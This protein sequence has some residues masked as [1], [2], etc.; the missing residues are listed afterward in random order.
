M[1][2]RIVWSL[3]IVLVASVASLAQLDRSARYS[4]ALAELVPAP[5]QAFAARHLAAEAILERDGETAL[6]LARA[7]VKVRPVPAEHMT[8]LAQARGLAEDQPGALAALS[9]AIQRGW[10]D[11]VAQ[12][13]AAE[14]ALL[15]GD[16]TT[17]TQRISALLATE[18]LP[19]EMVRQLAR[20]LQNEA[21][22][23]AFAAALA[24]PGRWQSNL[25]TRAADSVAPADLAETLALALDQGADLPCSSLGYVAQS[26]RTNGFEAEAER[27]WPGACPL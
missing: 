26:Y 25:P 18:Q 11:P 8:M 21:G 15:S 4:P 17:A 22:R 3:A 24:A 20:L 7:L 10:R 12:Q 9:E 5:F 19:D 2:A 14:A 6:P 16:F 27:F 1:I 13:S 23:T